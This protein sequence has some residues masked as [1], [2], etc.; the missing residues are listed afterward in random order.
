VAYLL[1]RIELY[2]GIVILASNFRKNIDEAFV[3]RLQFQVEFPFPD[4]ARREEIWNRIWPDETPRK[5]N[6]DF[7]SIAEEF[8]ASGGNIKN[9]ALSAAFAAAGDRSR[10]NS[11][12][13]QKA[14]HREYRKM[15]RVFRS[16]K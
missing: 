6:L 4:A 1:Q 7:E 8:E 16:V 9:S 5:A 14:I 11:E 3:R 10:I 15:G 2:D 13:I 12:Y